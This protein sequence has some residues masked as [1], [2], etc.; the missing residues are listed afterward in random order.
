MK[1]LYEKVTGRDSP[2]RRDLR[3]EDM[4]NTTNHKLLSHRLVW[5]AVTVQVPLR[6]LLLVPEFREKFLKL[7]LTL[8]SCT[9]RARVSFYSLK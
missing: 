9:V 2:L 4:L 5:A 7:I 6:T 3:W 8:S 1:D